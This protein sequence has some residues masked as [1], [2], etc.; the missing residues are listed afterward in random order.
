[1]IFLMNFRLFVYDVGIYK[2]TS[3]QNTNRK[4]IVISSSYLI[5]DEVKLIDDVVRDF[6]LVLSNVAKACVVDVLLIFL[7]P[8]IHYLIEQFYSHVSERLQSFVVLMSSACS[9]GREVCLESSIDVGLFPSFVVRM[10]G[11][12]FVLDQVIHFSNREYSL[13]LG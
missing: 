9:D 13:G 5:I 6:S 3:K 11:L 7:F 12:V 2:F 10:L 4:I 8:Q 1:M